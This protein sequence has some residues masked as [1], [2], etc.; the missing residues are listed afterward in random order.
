MIFEL[1]AR[2]FPIDFNLNPIWRYHPILGWSQTPNFREDY[3]LEDKL[4]HVEFNSKGFRDVAHTVQKPPGTRR[5]VILGDSM[6]EAAQVNLGQTFFK[7]LEK[8]LNQSDNDRWEVVNLG[9][10][11]FGTAQEW[12]A[13][14]EYGFSYSPDIVICQIF[15]LNDICNNAIELYDLTM[16][17]MI[18]TAL[19]SF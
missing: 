11:D 17:I 6:C 4:V 16:A 15:P 8:R 5:I 2:L 19:I 14:N 10:G 13:L 7:L 12:I 1:A 9:A 18:A 3:P